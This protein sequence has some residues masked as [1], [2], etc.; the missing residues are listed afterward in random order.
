MRTYILNI[1]RCPHVKLAMG[2][3]LCAI[4]YARVD[5]ISD[6]AWYNCNFIDN[7]LTLVYL[8]VKDAAL[9]FTLLTVCR[10]FKI[11]CIRC[12]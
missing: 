6:D 9:S 4:R 5:E 3:A 7:L 2:T 1:R 10:P 8:G 11:V 12:I